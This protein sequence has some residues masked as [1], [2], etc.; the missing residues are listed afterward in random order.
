MRLLILYYSQFGHIY[1]MANAEAEGAQG[2]PGAEVVI[3]RVPETLPAEVLEKTGAAE[4]QKEF[5]KNR[6]V[7]PVK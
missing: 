7:L 1:R 4:F 2:V 5:S 3:R 6:S